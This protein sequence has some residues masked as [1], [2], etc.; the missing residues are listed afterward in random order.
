[1]AGPKSFL[2]FGAQRPCIVLAPQCPKQINWAGSPGDAVLDL[3]RDILKESAAVDPSRVYLT[4][5]SLG[6]VG[7]W[8]LLGKAPD[9]F[10]AAV[11]V[12]GFGDPNI[13]SRLTKV[14]VWIFHGE[15]D[16]SVGIAHGRKMAAAMKKAHAP[17]TYTE[18]KGVGHNISSK[19]YFNEKMHQWLFAQRRR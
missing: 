8:S 17:V 10:A 1:M 9:L 6:G 11:P 14:P 2:N 4:G 3:V 18:M 19:V 5:Y 15:R 16:K 7:T 12:A 13:A